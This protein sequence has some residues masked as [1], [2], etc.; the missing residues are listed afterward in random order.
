[1]RIFR[2][3]Q[4]EIEMDLELRS[5]I[6]AYAEDLIAQGVAPDEAGRI[7]RREF[8]SVAAKKDECRREL[9]AASG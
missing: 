1:M 5:H 2:R 6:E 9:G 3:K 7:A 8:G 4:F